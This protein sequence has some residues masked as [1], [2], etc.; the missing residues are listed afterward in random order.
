MIAAKREKEK[1]KHLIRNQLVGKLLHSNLKAFFVPPRA[2]VYLNAL[3]FCIS[4]GRKRDATPTNPDR[5]GPKSDLLQQA[6]SEDES[7]T[8]PR[9]CDDRKADSGAHTTTGPALE[10]EGPG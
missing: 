9:Q 1:W 5:Y 7:P 3:R 10:F 4:D 6:T 2:Y 8:S